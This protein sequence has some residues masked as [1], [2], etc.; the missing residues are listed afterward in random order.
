MKGLSISGLV[1]GITA[2]GIGMAAIVLAAIA[3]GKDGK[4]F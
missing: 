4:E 2:T 1:L 3:L